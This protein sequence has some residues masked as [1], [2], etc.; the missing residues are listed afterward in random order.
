MST[1]QNLIFENITV[2]ESQFKY[3]IF[4]NNSKNVDLINITI[5]SKNYSEFSFVQLFN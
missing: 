1:T 2:I 5:K 3:F 4:G